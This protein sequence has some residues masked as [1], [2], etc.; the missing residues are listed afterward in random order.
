M[1]NESHRDDRIELAGS[2]SRKALAMPAMGT[3]I[4]AGFPSPADDYLEGEID[5][6]EVLMPNRSAS[7]L[8][9]V[10]GRSMVLTGVF[11]GDVVV[12]DRSLTPK[13][14][15]VV[16]ATVD[17]EVSLKL[18][19]TNPARLEFANPDMPAFKLAESSDVAVWGVVTWTLHKPCM[20]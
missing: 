14:G 10:S 13:N 11:D 15:D 6:A 1:A 17:G 4:C 16:V 19:R 8:W 12:V 18:F 20:P 5:L 2:A 3:S 9:R 7:F